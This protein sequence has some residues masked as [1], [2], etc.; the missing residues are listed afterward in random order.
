MAERVRPPSTL[1]RRLATVPG[2][3]WVTALVL[4]ALLTALLVSILVP[5]TGSGI[6]AS[7]QALPA[8]ADDHQLPVRYV[9]TAPPQDAVQCTVEAIDQDHLLVGSILDTVGIRRN[10]QRSTTRDVRVPTS[11]RAV[12]AQ[13]GN[14]H[15][16][17]PGQR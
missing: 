14:C 3:A 4:G 16:L 5:G 1:G 15:R 10:G 6:S 2:W 13:I 11:H 7:L 8:G 17:A 12:S 9:L